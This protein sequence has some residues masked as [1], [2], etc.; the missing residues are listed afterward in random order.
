MKHFK[1][2]ETGIIRRFDNGVIHLPKSV[3]SNLGIVHG[4]SFEI[5]TM[6]DGSILLKRINETEDKHNV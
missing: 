4:S 3:T 6:Y 2:Y 1:A 5:C